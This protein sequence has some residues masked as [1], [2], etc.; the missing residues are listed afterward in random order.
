MP[1]NT[2]GLTGGRS[3]NVIGG[4]FADYRVPDVTESY[5]RSINGPQAG[6]S[7]DV[8]YSGGTGS[9]LG[10]DLTDVASDYFLLMWITAN[11]DFVG[12]DTGHYGHVCCR[13]G[14]GASTVDA[15]GTDAT[16]FA[17]LVVGD[18]DRID[19]DTLMSIGTGPGGGRNSEWGVNMVLDDAS[20]LYMNGASLF[21][22][23]A[24]DASFVGST[25]GMRDNTWDLALPTAIAC[26]NQVGGDEDQTVT[27][28]LTLGH[29]GRHLL[30]VQNRL[31][32][33]AT[34]TAANASVRWYNT[35]NGSD[36][37]NVRTNA[38][39]STLTGRG[40][41]FGITR[42]PTGSPRYEMCAF[43]VKNLAVG[44][45]IVSTI[46]NRH[47]SADT[48]EQISLNR[49]VAINI[50]MFSKFLYK[51]LTTAQSTSSAIYAD[52]SMQA[53]TIAVDG[54][55][56][57]ALFFSTTIHTNHSQYPLF[58]ITRNGAAITPNGTDAG[59]NL[60]PTLLGS[61]AQYA[62]S[63]LGATPDNETLPFSIMWIDDPGAGTHIYRVQVRA[64]ISTC[65]WNT[66]DDGTDGYVGLFAAAELKFATSGY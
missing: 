15:T 12:G 43:A 66:R 23:P 38:V 49:F 29:A 4:S 59:S 18:A 28:T 36:P 56:K 44:D 65:M 32:H 7:T 25:L 8:L 41:H 64:G 58:R 61:H 35:V 54:T 40:Y 47:E 3:I 22:A 37:W 13:E 27:A 52:S 5:F 45:T 16:P 9:V 34:G 2:I 50:N 20:R 60:Y 30:I 21:I 17:P 53:I 1:K 24:N 14:A 6:I 10:A 62:P 11:V 63:G 55:A 33:S 19:F 39:G 57:V 51:E 42:D 46:G 48:N 31:T 26:N